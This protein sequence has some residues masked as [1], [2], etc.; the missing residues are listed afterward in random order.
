L[1]D[2]TGSQKSTK[3][4]RLVRVTPLGEIVLALLLLS[5]VGISP[6]GPRPSPSEA[7]ATT[8]P[9]AAATARLAETTA[10]RPTEKP[11]TTRQAPSYRWNHYVVHG[12][13]G[14]TALAVNPL[15][16][17]VV[18]ATMDHGGIVKS[19]DYGDTWQTINNNIGRT[20]LADV[21]LDP[22][23][24]DILYVAAAEGKGYG[25]GE[26]YR[27]LDGGT[28]WE[29]LT[30]A[31]GIEKWPSTRAM[32]ILPQDADGDQVSDVIYVG[33]WAGEEGSDRGGIWQS[34]DEGTTWQQ[35]GCVGRDCELFKRAN[36]WVLRTDPSNADILYAG[37]Y[38]YQDVDTPGGI[39][40]STDGG[41]NWRDITNQIP[42][43]YVSDIAISPDGDTLYAATNTV[44]DSEPGVGIFKS[45]D[46]G[47]T[48]TPINRGLEKTSLKFE[49]VLMD[50][51]EPDVLYTGPFRGGQGMYK[52]IDGGGHWYRTQIDYDGWWERFGN[53]WAIA[54]GSDSRLY[55]GT[56]NAIYRSDDDGE[57]WLVRPQGLGNV[58]VLDIALDPQNP[59]IV[60]LGLADRGPWKSIDGGHTWS[61]IKDGYYEPYGKSSGSVAAFAISPSH[62][63]IIY[64]AVQ[65]SAGTTLMGVNKTVNGGKRWQAVNRGLPGPDPAW[66]ANDVIVHTF[67][68][69]IAY[70][71]LEVADGTGRVFKT[72]NGGKSWTELSLDPTGRLP[73]VECIAIS[74][75]DPE[76]VLVGTKQPGRVY[77]TTDGGGAWSSISPSADLMDPNTIVYDIDIHPRE[78]EQMIIGTNTE[79]AY[80]TSDGGQTWTLILGVDPFQDNVGDLVLDPEESIYAR[81]RALRFDPD[82]PQTIY[83]GHDN[84]GGKGGFGVV[85]STDGGTSWAFINDPGLQYR[86]I[87]TMEV[88]PQTKELFVGG[89]DGVYIYE[90]FSPDQ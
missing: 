26:L 70:V 23:N 34:S 4:Q 47:D 11:D 44:A 48:W 68:P 38:V 88:N 2:R 18:Y 33:A 35:I 75:S 16:P 59:S 50:K 7:L 83:A 22:L 41:L 61:Q 56:W 37:M 39:W 54:G 79:G 29:F 72:V 82:D 65:G 53:A 84:R 52:T 64:S 9:D 12:G 87:F 73:R 25:L 17:N 89:F 3:S 21:E 63:K 6:T 46:G 19:T 69:D 13:G 8:T 30:S 71:G 90:L 43:P 62:P 49:I 78:P 31:F 10:I 57:S 32:V 5:C 20:R 27:S 66:I 15:S 74:A 24:P 80:K 28:H 85:K 77:K 58:M 81:I 42:V 45:A 60:Y 67:K 1:S 51:D 36:V 76:L 86:N 40:K 55:V 14:Q